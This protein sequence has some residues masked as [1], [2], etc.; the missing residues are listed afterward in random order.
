MEP[1]SVDVTGLSTWQL[2]ATSATPTV[3]VCILG[4]VGAILAH[5]ASQKRTATPQPRAQLLSTSLRVQQAG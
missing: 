3:I 5:K 4:A 2:V 1:P